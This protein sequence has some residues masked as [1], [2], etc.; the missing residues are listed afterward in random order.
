MLDLSQPDAHVVAYFILDG[1]RYEVEKFQIGFAQSADYKGQPEEEVKGG[2]MSIT[3]PQA[4]DNTLY[5]WAKQSVLLK[6]GEVVFQT[7][8]GKS[9]LRISFTNAYCVSL[10][11]Q[12]S[13]LTGTNTSLIITP[14][15]ITLNDITH[16]NVWTKS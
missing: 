12:L 7:D 16:D 1:I 5:S 9:V 4:A 6:D 15:T 2:Q 11:R 13:A 3:I 8:M 14:E 10:T